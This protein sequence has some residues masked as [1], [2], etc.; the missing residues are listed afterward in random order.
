MAAFHRLH[1]LLLLLSGLT[2]QAAFV[3]IDFGSEWTKVSLMTPGRPIDVLLN[4]DSK[5][6][7]QSVVAWNKNERSFGTDA[8]NL[9]ARFPTDSFPYLKFLQGCRCDGYRHRLYSQISAANVME[10]PSRH[11]CIVQR[12]DGSQWSVE[13]LIAMQF[14]YIKQLAERESNERMSEAVVTVPPYYTQFERQAVMDALQVAGMKPIALINDGLAVGIN[15]AMS[16]TISAE[17]H[18]IIYDAGASS[19]TAT[20]I[21]FSTQPIVVPGKVLKS[22]KNATHV[23]VQSFGYDTVA[24]G[25]EL[26]RRLRDY[27]AQLFDTKHHKVVSGNERAM[28][29]LWKE[30][31]RVKSVLSA[32][33]DSTVRVESL[34]DDIDLKDT[35][36]RATFETLAK[37]LRGRFSEPIVQA[38]NAAG[39]TMDNITSV[40]LTGGI[41]RIPMIRSAVQKVAGEK[42]AVSVNA[43]EA[44]VLG[45]AFYGATTKSTWRTKDMRFQDLGAYDVQLKYRK[46]NSAKE[47][48]SSVFTPRSK[49]GTTN[50][51]KL[52]FAK[53]TEDFGITVAYKNNPRPD[54]SEDIMTVRFSGVAEALK[55][56]TTS[57]AVEH[58]QITAS[59]AYSD[60]GMII[61]EDAQMVAD[62]KMPETTSAPKI[63]VEGGENSTSRPEDQ[64]QNT[65]QRMSVP[66][67]IELE[68]LA[69]PRLTE[70]VKFTAQTRLTNILEAEA[71]KS[72]REE[73]YN[74]LEGYLYRLRDLISGD[75]GTPFK[76]FVQPAELS[77]LSRGLDETLQ[78]L[79]EEADD[80][81][82]T[83]LW[84]KRNDL[85]KVE[86][87]VISRYKEAEAGPA[88]L[89]D[90]QK[91]LALSREFLREAHANRT[92]ALEG[93]Y[94]PRFTEEE[95]AAVESSVQETEEWLKDLIPKQQALAK[96]SDPVLKAMEM[97]QRGVALQKMVKNLEKK[98][99]PKPPRASTSAPTSTE[100]SQSSSTASNDPPRETVTRDEL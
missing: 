71:A 98:R 33:T 74:N 90:L 82:A 11:T 41:S 45:A 3:A 2:C 43:D 58:P 49:V 79:N 23:A 47:L 30:A 19:I 35:V 87:P 64:E 25:M 80:A 24:T 66:L 36:S 56:L 52:T 32:N 7:M 62:V 88:A 37:D 77:S 18:H 51:K 38:L 76:E 46:E 8:F 61:V 31:Q 92:I 20:V 39:M 28:A 96:R 57:G 73:A 83:L 81:D 29:R 1:F 17:E 94:Q 5:R 48:A 95:L 100:S 9:A 15:Y 63:V 53:R 69:I 86:Q 4:T 70:E 72:R 10:D 93:D 54:F 6:K 13:E 22:S 65:L 89:K 60:S 16:R 34:L 14:M 91:A 50:G 40:I 27:L 12:P 67:R 55:N 97:D 44:A 59:F 26:D 99:H 21:S 84:K 85:E 75:D 68:P 42:I 78:W